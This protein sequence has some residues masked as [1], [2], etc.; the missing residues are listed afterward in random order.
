[1]KIT[2][3]KE[4]FKKIHP[5]LKVAFI[6]ATGV[7]NKTQ[8]KKMNHLLAEM[9][10]AVLLIFNQD[11]VKTH[12]L[13]SPWTAAKEEF[14]KKAK[15]Y[16]TSV[17]VLLQ[18]VLRKQSIK[19]KDTVTALLRYLALKHIV[20]VSADDPTKIKG[21]LTF[22]MSKD[23]LCYKDEKRILG[24]KLD[25]WKNN[26]TAMMPLSWSTLVHFEFLPPV[27]AQKQREIVNE[28]VELLQSCCG[29]ETRVAF[30]DRKN[31][32]VEFK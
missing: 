31:N 14:G 21:D 29:A 22:Q 19:S 9:Q 7:D 11:N 10:K 28:T 16:N 15:H 3:K 26:K 27:S 25:H 6:H 23:D 24:R 32:S 4:V 18:K 5:K 20:P 2:I 12:L 8:A 17:E 30:L 1:M 13:I